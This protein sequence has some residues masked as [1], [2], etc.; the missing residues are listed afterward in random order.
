MTDPDI[1]GCAFCVMHVVAI[2]DPGTQTLFAQPILPYLHLS[3]THKVLRHALYMVSW[4]DLSQLVTFAVIF[5]LLAAH[6]KQ[7]PLW[8]YLCKIKAPCLASSWPSCCGKF[9]HDTQAAALGDKGVKGGFLAA[10]R[11]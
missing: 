4:R 9:F 3:Q 10:K 8:K 11:V 6:L 7:L 1:S 2:P 5:L